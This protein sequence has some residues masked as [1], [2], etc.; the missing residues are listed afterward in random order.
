MELSIGK[1]SF[2]NCFEAI[3]NDNISPKNKLNVFLLKTNAN[4]FD[5]K[6]LEGSLLEPMASYALSRKIKEKYKERPIELSRIA[7]Q[8]FKSDRK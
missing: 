2:L 7:R 1:N 5:Y 4:D 6:M 3:K 8:R